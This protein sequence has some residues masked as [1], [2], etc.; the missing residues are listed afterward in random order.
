MT[1]A[2]KRLA[3]ARRIRHHQAQILEQLREG[4]ILIKRVIER[5]GDAAARLTVHVL[6]TNTKHI[7]ERGAEHICKRADVWP[8]HRL[9]ELSEKERAD[10][11]DALPPRAR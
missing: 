5:P 4:E 8:T 11:V 10:L 1:S 6:L 2:E 7:G 3:R 9:S